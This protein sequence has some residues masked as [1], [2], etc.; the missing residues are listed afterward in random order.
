[1]IGQPVRALRQFGEG[2]PGLAAT[3]LDDPQ[4]ALIGLA[5]RDIVEKALTIAGDMCIY[6]NHNRVIE[7]I[8]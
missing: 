4:R 3:F 1:M 6:T 8:E 5:P 2:Q 7:T